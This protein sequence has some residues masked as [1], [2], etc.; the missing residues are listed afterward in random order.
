MNPG[1][2]ELERLAK[3]DRKRWLQEISVRYARRKRDTFTAW[4]IA[5][6]GVALFVWVVTRI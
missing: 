3:R 6:I 5:G 4:A 1:R 2:K